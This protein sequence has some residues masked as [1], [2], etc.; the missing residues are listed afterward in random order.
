MTP[1]FKTRAFVSTKREF[2]KRW[3]KNWKTSC[4][5]THGFVSTKPHFFKKRGASWAPFGLHFGSLW[6]SL[7]HP[8]GVPKRLPRRGPRWEGSFFKTK[9][10]VY[11]KP[12]FWKP[13]LACEREAVELLNVSK[14]GEAFPTITLERSK[15]VGKRASSSSASRNMQCVAKV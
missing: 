5:K 15:Q 3:K 7:G 11:T 8:R 10:F 2:A 9:G 1:F 12:Y 14:H 6:G 13:V 4:F